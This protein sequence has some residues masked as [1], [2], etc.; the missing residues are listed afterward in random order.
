MVFWRAIVPL[1]ASLITVAVFA[2]ERINY[3]R[4]ERD[5]IFRRLRKVTRGDAERLATLRELFE[6]SGCKDSNLVDQ[7]VQDS[8]LPNLVCT[9]PGDTELQIV[10]GAHFDADPA[11]E[12]A[13]D[14]WTGAALLPSLYRS[15]STRPRRHTLIFVAFAGGEDRHLGSKHYADALTKAEAREIRAMVNLESLGLTRTLS[16]QFGGERELQLLVGEV[17]RHT[18]LPTDPLHPKQL[19]RV[20][21]ESFA[22]RGIPS[23]VLHSVSKYNYEA[24]HSAEDT[25]DAVKR[26]EYY[27]SYMLIAS[28]LAYLDVELR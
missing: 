26:D 17:G 12:G 6:E 23:I 18:M 15:L 16:W 11:G 1:V 19:G 8:E 24:R 14:N 3:T 5:E 9:L 4:L 10:I 25:L 2:Q 7:P 21:A 13:V 28:Y 20:D 27:E 22:R